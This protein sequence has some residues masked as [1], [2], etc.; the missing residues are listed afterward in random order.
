MYPLRDQIFFGCVCH[1][2]IALYPS[3]AC[4]CAA[5]VQ[6]RGSDINMR[7]PSRPLSPCGN[8]KAVSMP[9]FRWRRE[10]RKRSYVRRARKAIEGG[11]EKETNK[12]WNL[13]KSRQKGG[14][15]KEKGHVRLESSVLNAMKWLIQ[16][17]GGGMAR[18]WKRLKRGKTGMKGADF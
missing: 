12:A 11:W 4:V 6:C 15:R 16:R 9:L 5:D 7:Q 3:T 10:R 8:W 2:D 14:E 1:F 17:A 18:D 13:E